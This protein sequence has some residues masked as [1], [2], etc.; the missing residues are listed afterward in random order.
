M[1]WQYMEISP[2]NREAKKI[3]IMEGG[4]HNSLQGADLQ[5]PKYLA[6]V[7]YH[8]MSVETREQLWLLR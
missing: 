8:C 7:F 4:P 3:K 2:M 1:P 5:W 6:G